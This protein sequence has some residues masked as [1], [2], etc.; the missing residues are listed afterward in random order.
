M[1]DKDISRLSRLIA[2]LTQLQSKRL[3]TS[4]ELAAK[5]NVS[6]RTVYRDIR[7][8]DEAGVP[9]MTAEG[10]GYSLME[11]YR[12]P[13]V[14]FTEQEANAFI[15]AEKLVLLNKDSSLT[16]NYVDGITKIKSVLRSGAKDK[17][18]MLSERVAFEESQ[19]QNITSDILASVQVALTN[20]RIVEIEY[21]SPTKDETTN[22]QIEPFA[23]INRV[24]ESW[25]LVAWCRTRQDFRLFRFDRIR[26]IEIT[27]DP[28]TP[29]KISLQ[30]YLEKYRSNF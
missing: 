29:H 12:L 18:S 1:I 3:V 9:I 30:E 10:K 14:M 16:K 13:P 11:G 8:L 4:T 17:L 24:G 7:T 20:F 25:Y 19:D 22:R 6:V 27:D 28:F 21:Y 23:V 2:I 15:T 26:K 5:F